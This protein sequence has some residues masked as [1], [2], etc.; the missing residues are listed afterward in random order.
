MIVRRWARGA[1]MR[2]PSCPCAV[3]MTILVLNWVNERPYLFLQVP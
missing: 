1:N 3:S 2:K